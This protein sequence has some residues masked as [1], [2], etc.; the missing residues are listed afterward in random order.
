MAVCRFLVIDQISDSRRAILVALKQRGPLTIAQLAEILAL[1][2]EAV[3]Q[4]LLQLQRDGWVE[5]RATTVAGERPKTGRPAV[6]YSL[7]QAGD[8][9]FPKHYAELT[10]AMLDTVASEFGETAVS[11][12]LERLTDDRVAAVEPSV[13]GM[14]LDQKVASLKSWYLEDDPFMESGAD[15]K[16]YRLVERNCPFLNTALQRPKLCS[17]SVNALTRILGYRVERDEKFQHGD[18]RCV[19]RVLENEPVDAA[20][21]KFQ[22]EPEFNR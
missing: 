18:G 13:R 10:V 22:L 6:T 2:G 7:T 12:V 8:H 5:T 19:F 14:S 11:K 1:T 9:L 20:Q 3:R 15:D 21:W 16:G 4:Q 17:I